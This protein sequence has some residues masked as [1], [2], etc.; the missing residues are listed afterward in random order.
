MFLFVNPVKL[1]K[2]II[3]I[4]IALTTKLITP[5]NL[6][7]LI[8]GA[9]PLFFPKLVAYIIYTFFMTT[10][11][12]FGSKQKLKLF[13]PFVTFKTSVEK[14]LNRSI[15]VVQSDYGGEFKAFLPLFWQHGI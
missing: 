5:L 1:V 3:Y 13:L 15:K 11:D 10:P 6:C 2:A 12:L 14:Q 8:F 4:F 7:T 9:R